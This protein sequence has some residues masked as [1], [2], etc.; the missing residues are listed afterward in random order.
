M[1]AWIYQ[2]QVTVDNIIDLPV[3]TTLPLD[4]GR[5]LEGAR[6]A[7]LSEVIVI[8]TKEDGKL[9]FASSESDAAPVLWL[10]ELVKRHLLE[11][12]E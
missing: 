2:G 6:A 1:P 3:V 4:V 9:Y 8:G 11:A 7:G 10:L 5:V 12:A